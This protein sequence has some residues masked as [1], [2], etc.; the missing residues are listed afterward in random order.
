MW[1]IVI[2][3]IMLYDEKIFDKKETKDIFNQIFKTLL[4]KL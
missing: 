3:V 4:M 1:V 2:F